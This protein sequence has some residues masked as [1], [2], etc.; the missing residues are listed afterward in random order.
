MKSNK[1][2]CGEWW[3]RYIMKIRSARP[4]GILWKSIERKTYSV[5]FI[6]SKTAEKHNNII[7]F[8]AICSKH[9]PRT[10]KLDE[11][12]SF[13]YWS[14]LWIREVYWRQIIIFL[15]FF[16]HTNVHA[17]AFDVS[18]YVTI[19]YDR[20][21]KRASKCTVV[22]ILDRKFEYRYMVWIYNCSR[23]NVFK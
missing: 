21:I 13:V 10:R 12:L 11:Y 8:S 6:A 18:V 20:K 17:R 15:D 1:I 14:F 2:Y 22:T 16:F 5:F 7:Q 9:T 19:Y 4:I 23:L 3:R